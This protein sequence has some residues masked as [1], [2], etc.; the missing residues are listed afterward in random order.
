MSGASAARSVVGRRSGEGTG[1]DPGSRQ[2]S[3][4]RPPLGLVIA[5]K[6]SHEFT[7]DGVTSRNITLKYDFALRTSTGE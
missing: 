4:R 3:R 2:Q 5:G 1:D 7:V 6:E